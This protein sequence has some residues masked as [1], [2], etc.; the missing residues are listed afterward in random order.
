[1][2][3]VIVSNRLPVSIKKEAEGNHFQPSIG[4][5]AT[6]IS[7]FLNTQQDMDAL[8]V[9]WPGATIEKNKQKKVQEQ[10]A[11]DFRCHPVFLSESQMDKFYYG[12]CNKT[13]WP[14]FHYY[15]MLTSFDEKSCINGT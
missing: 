14:L 12:F 7:D 5:L 10:L 6:G 2:R 4:G 15:P 9:G 8:W 13:L 1:M 3:L 11:R